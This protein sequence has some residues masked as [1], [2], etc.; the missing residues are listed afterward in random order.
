MEKFSCLMSLYG[1]DDPGHFLEALQSVFSQSVVPDETVIIV[2]GKITPELE[3]ILQAYQSVRVHRLNENVG[4][5]AALG[6]ALPL[7]SYDLVAIMDAD[8][9][10]RPFRFEHQLAHFCVNLDSVLVGSHIR[11]FDLEPGDIDQHRKV[12]VSR[13][14]IK[15]VVKFRNPINHMTVMFRKKAVLAAG[16]YRNMPYFEDYD[17]VYRLISFS[18]CVDNLDEV[19]VDA[20]IGNNMYSRRV[21][22]GY[23]KREFDFLTALRRERVIGCFQYIG[24]ILSRLPLRFMPMSILKKVYR[25]FLR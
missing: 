20:R 22:F 21:G 11:E 24:M 16:G 18:D 15:R 10:C 23:A 19:L 13:S 6:I 8:D 1:G 17:M 3:K 9:V 25:S 14:E 7:C 5:G 4:R 12:P 2:D